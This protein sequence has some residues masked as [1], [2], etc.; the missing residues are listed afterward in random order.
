M[1]ALPRDVGDCFGFQKPKISEKQTARAEGEIWASF[2]LIYVTLL[3][4]SLIAA[5][6][7]RMIPTIVWNW[8]QKHLTGISKSVAGRR[9]S[10]SLT[11]GAQ[12]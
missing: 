6:P 4:S 8:T 2:G 11:Q 10:E 9:I 7:D 1:F 5:E 12:Q 3:F